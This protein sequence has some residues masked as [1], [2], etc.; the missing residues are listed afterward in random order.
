MSDRLLE[1]ASNYVCTDKR[2]TYK[3]YP[4]AQDIGFGNFNVV[5]NNKFV[6]KLLIKPSESLPT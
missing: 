6:S 1:L 4:A 2:S 5:I 3:L